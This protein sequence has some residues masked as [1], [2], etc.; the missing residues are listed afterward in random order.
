MV[1]SLAM[2]VGTI[3]RKTLLKICSNLNLLAT[4]RFFIK[5]FHANISIT[6]ISISEKESACLGYGFLKWSAQLKRSLRSKNFGD[7]LGD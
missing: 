2:R 5:E 6:D 4:R 1:L 3:F 7:S